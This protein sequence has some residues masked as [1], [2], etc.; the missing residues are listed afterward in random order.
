LELGVLLIF[1][2]GWPQ[3]TILPILAS[4]ITRITGMNCWCQPDVLE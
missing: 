2:L 1:C 4:Q 3:T